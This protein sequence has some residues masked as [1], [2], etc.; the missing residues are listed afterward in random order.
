MLQIKKKLNNDWRDSIGEGGENGSWRKNERL[1]EQ[2]AR[3]CEKHLCVASKHQ[4]SF[5][6]WAFL[7]FYFGFDWPRACGIWDLFFALLH[8]R[9][10]SF[11]HADLELL[12]DPA[13]FG[14]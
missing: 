13:Y 9:D 11:I 5:D 3:R 10:F 1:C 2:Y 7:W 4:P 8:D 14:F 12:A 6:F